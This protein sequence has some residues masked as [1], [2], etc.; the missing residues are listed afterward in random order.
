MGC[1]IEE[2]L[3]LMGCGYLPAFYPSS[4]GICPAFFGAK[5]DKYVKWN[6]PAFQHQIRLGEAAFPNVQKLENLVQ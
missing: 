5:G 3:I 4:C 6:L 1:F 2:L